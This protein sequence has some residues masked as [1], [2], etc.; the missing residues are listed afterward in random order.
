MK[1]LVTASAATAVL[2]A[3]AFPLADQAQARI[4]CNGPYQMVQ[5]SAV[6][7][8]YCEDNYAASVARGYGMR[9]SDAAVRQ[10]PSVKAEVCRWFGHDNRIRQIC[11]SY[12]PTFRRPF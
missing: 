8:P 5:G 2:S 3:V 9:V 12:Q 11:S 10:N 6:A 4:V 1:A 7:T